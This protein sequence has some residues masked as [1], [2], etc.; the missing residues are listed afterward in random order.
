MDFTELKSK[1]DILFF[2]SE[3]G[4]DGTRHG[5]CWQGGCLKH[6]SKNGYG[7]L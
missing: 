2:A 7:Y 1:V 3:L 5:S 4:F 6:D